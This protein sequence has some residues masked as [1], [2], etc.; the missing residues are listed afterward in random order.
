M[1]TA[2]V[3]GPADE[4]DARAA[5]DDRAGTARLRLR[6]VFGAQDS[7]FA[8]AMPLGMVLS[9]HMKVPAELRGKL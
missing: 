4:A 6:P 3:L 1:V 8:A 7:A 9:R 5:V 2:T